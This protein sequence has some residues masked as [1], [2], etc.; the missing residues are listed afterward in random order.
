MNS[1]RRFPTILLILPLVARVA[2]AAALPAWIPTVAENAAP[3]G[4]R[5]VFAGLRE[6]VLTVVCERSREGDEVVVHDLAKIQ[7]GSRDVQPG[8][9]GLVKIILPQRAARGVHLVEFVRRGRILD[10]AKV[11]PEL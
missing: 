4:P 9:G 11:A 10:Q 2:P 1:V 8:S 3:R 5:I 7:V 6:R